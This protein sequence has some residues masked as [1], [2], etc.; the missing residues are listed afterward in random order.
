MPRHCHPSPTS[1]SIKSRTWGDE[2]VARY[3]PWGIGKVTVELRVGRPAEEILAVAAE[4]GAQLIALGWSQEIDWGRAPIVREVLERGRTPV[5]LV[6]VRLIG[7]EQG[8]KGESWNKS[9]YWPQLKEG[10][11]PRAAELIAHGPPFDPGTTGFDRHTVYLSA[12]EVVFVFEGTEVEWMIDALVDEPFHWPVLSALDEWR[13]LLEGNP[14][15]RAS[16]IFVAARRL[17]RKPDP[18]EI[19]RFHG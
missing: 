12:D 6:P 13:P 1:L 9:Q 3:C 7:R 4:T 17:G 2:F 16:C 10:A 14:R 19:A 5:L 11:E 15:I 18:G 8:L